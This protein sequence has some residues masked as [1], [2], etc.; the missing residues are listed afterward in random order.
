MHWPHKKNTTRSKNK[1]LTGTSISSIAER[2]ANLSEDS[3]L[4]FLNTLVKACNKNTLIKFI[5]E[6]IHSSYIMTSNTYT[7]LGTRSSKKVL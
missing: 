5:V 2:Q 4:Q 6:E 7:Q 3:G 1:V